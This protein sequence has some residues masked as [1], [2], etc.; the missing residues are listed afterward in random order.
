MQRKLVPAREATTFHWIS[1][2]MDCDQ[3]AA[4][5][6]HRLEHGF[7]RTNTDPP[8]PRSANGPS[9]APNHDGRRAAQLPN[10]SLPA[11]M[12]YQ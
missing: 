8:F 6:T 9:S 7:P 12:N 11:I 2:G 10:G 4:D 1:L 3:L 5:W